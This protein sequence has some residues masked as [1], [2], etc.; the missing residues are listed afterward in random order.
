MELSYLEHAYKIKIR[1]SC[2]YIVGE[3]GRGVL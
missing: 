3:K 2:P 1:K